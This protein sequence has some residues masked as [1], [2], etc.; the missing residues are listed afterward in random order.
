MR[1]I[2]KGFVDL[3]VHAGPSI[4]KRDVDSADLIKAAKA[5][6][7]RAVLVK[8]HYFPTVMHCQVAQK[9]F[10]DDTIDIFGSIV[11]NNSVGLFNLKA[12]DTAYNMGAKIAWFPTVSARN[13]VANHK[14]K[15]V[16]SGNSSVDENLVVYVDEQGVMDPAAIEVLKYMAEKDMVLGTGHGSAWEI[17]HL[18]K[19][20]L[21]LGVKRILVSHP[22]FLIG[23]PFEQI[24]EW[25]KMGAFIELN[26]AVIKGISTVGSLEWEVHDEM[27]KH[28]PLE[29]IILDSDFGQAG[30]GCP[31]DGMYRYI[32][33]L[34]ER[35]G[36]SEAD[37]NL[38]GKTNPSNL[39]D[40]K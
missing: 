19:K 10:G 29:Q 31:V 21:E 23:A 36:L 37:I 17:D 34:M 2:L 14:G 12:I 15:F 22:H 30:N 5:A 13:H 3:H 27:F 24:G 39:I 4:A 40:L 6:G 9:H 25:A 28:V 7:Y 11:L 1:E 35:N 18:I 16:G 26:A 8:D 32:Q 20:A 33:A 38:I